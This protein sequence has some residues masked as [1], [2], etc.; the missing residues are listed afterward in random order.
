MG[1]S[2]VQNP[3]EEDSGH[4]SKRRRVASSGENLE[5]ATA[6]AEV[7]PHK[8][9]H[10]Y[11]VMD[12][13]SFPLIY[14]DWNADEEIL[15]LEGIEM[16]GLG[17]WMEVAEHV[18]TKSKAQC[19][20]HYNIAYMN[21][22]CYP[23]PDMS[24]VVGKNR[25]ELLA[26]AKVQGDGKKDGDSGE[27][28]ITGAGYNSMNASSAGADT[29]VDRSVG[30]KKPKYSGDEGPSM[31]EL[32]GYN[33]KRQEFD[34]EYDNDAEQPLAEMEFKDNDSE[35]DRELKIRVLHNYI[36]RLDERKRRKDFILER[37]LLYP[38]PLEKDLSN[39]GK[40]IYQRYKECRAV[41]CHTMAE[42]KSYLAQKRK[43]ESEANA[44]KAKENGQPVTSTKPQPKA[45][46]PVHN[47][48][49]ES[50]GSP[51]SVID[52][53]KVKGVAVID[54]GGKDSSSITA[55]IT[56]S[57]EEWDIT[58][59][60]GEE[61]LS[62]AEQQLC[63]QCR[64]IPSQY[65]KMQESLVTEAM[66]GNVLKKSDARQLFKGFSTETLHSFKLLSASVAASAAAASV[67][68][69]RPFPSRYLFGRWFRE[70]Q[71]ALLELKIEKSWLLLELP[72]HL[73]QLS[74]D[75]NWSSSPVVL[76]SG[77]ISVAACDAGVA[78][79]GDYVSSI[80]G[81]SE[82]I[83]SDSSVKIYSKEYPLELKPLFSAFRLRAL[84]VT[85]LKSFLMYYLPLLEPRAP[86][87]E[88][89]D[90]DIL[91]DPPA[92]QPLDLVVPFKQSVKQIIREVLK[93]I[94]SYDIEYFVKRYLLGVVASWLV[95]IGIETY[96]CWTYGDDEDEE[97][98]NTERLRLFLRRIRGATV[99]C[100][101]SLV[102]A[103]IGA[104]IGA[105]LFSPSR[106]QWIGCA[107]GD[108]AGPYIVAFCFK[109]IH[110]AEP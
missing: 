84:L 32:S 54:G 9:N 66:K 89:D 39:E 1:R 31:T 52:N 13:L 7:T 51:Q 90:D 78:L 97:V 46:R 83:Y 5:A 101:S 96:R 57:L 53:I 80:H 37:N 110:L 17:N 107:L 6:G 34:P 38:N 8:S 2:R 43:K 82:D 24:H 25:K 71:M 19:I 26:M 18:G 108:A 93:V 62:E 77:G 109:K 55:N 95:K 98:D 15:L 99:R 64:L 49:S 48:K 79:N 23:L 27:S 33:S 65:L 30:V 21:S 16:Y 41:G 85:S 10:P 67:A 68:A 74:N 20:D 59:L 29:Q 56:K 94:Y 61:L 35:I 36:S 103:S 102:F 75:E 47:V 14:P 69:C 4:R 104:G 12:N 42:V 92:E 40:E 106:G 11:R 58:G 100:C 60:P 70:V 22:P 105:S 88:D 81:P 87:I 28:K 45:N 72:P 76:S 86:R 44:R 50:D 63:I 73:S 91:E 3:N